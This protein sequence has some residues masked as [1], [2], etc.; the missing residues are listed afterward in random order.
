MGGQ[1]VLVEPNESLQ[2]LYPEIAKEWHPDK[3]KNQSLNQIK[4]GTYEVAW[5]LCPK[6]H[7][8][9]KSV[10][11]RT[12]D[13]EGCHFC[14]K[15]E[16]NCLQTINPELSKEW[17]PTKNGDLTPR[18]VSK[19]SLQKVWWL[20]K[21]G[22]EWQEII[23]YRVKNKRSGCLRCKSVAFLNPVLVKEWHPEKNKDRA[24]DKVYPDS[25]R[26]VWWKCE[27]GHE[28]KG[29]LYWRI[30]KNRG[31]PF[32]SGEAAISKI[33]SEFPSLIKE[34]DFPKNQNLRLEDISSD[35]SKFAWW[36]CK[37][38]HKW[39]GIIWMRTKEGLGCPE[40]Q[41]RYLW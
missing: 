30:K 28:W 8:Y 24:P 16:E 10:K 3:N 33:F 15:K 9:K 1:K 27:K 17:H 14:R 26:K 6:G 12:I 32:C 25:S 29:Y 31:C 39:R 21:N 38:G 22:H 41:R 13:G 18:D 36:I 37:N 4:P 2:A 5:W 40:C 35:S 23:S 20:C 34:W 7:S 19:R 11:Y